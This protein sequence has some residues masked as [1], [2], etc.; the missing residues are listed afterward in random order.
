MEFGRKVGWQVGSEVTGK[1]G[2]WE[3]GGTLDIGRQCYPVG[4]EEKDVGKK[5][6]TCVETVEVFGH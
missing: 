2:R 1:T 6:D 3:G 4:E 5:V